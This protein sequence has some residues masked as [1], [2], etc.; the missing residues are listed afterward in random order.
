MTQ[1]GLSFLPD[2]DH[3]DKSPVQYY[4]DTL[5]LCDLAD[6]GKMSAVKMTQHY[7]HPYGGYCPNPLSFLMAVA[8]R[9]RHIKL[10]TGGII[11]SFFHPVK[12]AAEIAMLDAISN[13][14]AEVGF[15]RGFLPYEFETFDIP[16]DESRDR[17][18]KTIH[19]LIDLWT[20]ENV[21]HNTSYFSYENVNNYPKC[22]QQP[23]PP[24]WCAA[25]RSR[26]TFIWIAENQFNLMMA[27]TIQEREW[28]KDQIDL[29]KEEYPG[30]KITLLA[31][32][33]LDKSQKKAEEL[34]KH[35]LE[36]YHSVWFDASSSW[37]TKKSSS[38]PGY[39]GMA[40]YIK[41]HN[42]D[43]I[44]ALGNAFFGTPE[45]VKEEIQALTEDLPI[46]QLLFNVDIGSMPLSISKNTLELF[47]KHVI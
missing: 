8:A 46:D 9:T 14:R 28:L 42:Y 18:E 38:Y 30:G 35:Y 15:V 11:P 45:R 32:M 17:F 29:Y 12:L 27:L 3:N 40:N 19:A 47:L 44:K 31:P 2:S 4:R 36:K 24:I 22:T 20:K 7:M 16:L 13:G 26:E 23:H 37:D 41:L 25:A 43:K 39:T 34:G 33:L 10:M 1:F 6:Q 21:S 5:E